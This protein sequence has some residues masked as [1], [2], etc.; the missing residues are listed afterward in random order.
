MA[1]LYRFLLKSHWHSRRRVLLVGLLVLLTWVA[2]FWFAQQQQAE[3]QLADQTRQDNVRLITTGIP[4]AGIFPPTKEATEKAGL[5]HFFAVTQQ[6][7]ALTDP[8]QTQNEEVATQA[9]FQHNF[10]VPLGAN[11]LPGT[12]RFGPVSFTQTLRQRAQLAKNLAQ[13]RQPL[14]SMR[15]GTQ[16]WSFVISFLPLLTSILGV[17]VMTL[18]LFVEEISDTMSARRRFV[19]C[20]PGQRWQ[21]FLAQ[22]LVFGTDTVITLVLMLGGGIAMAGL[23]GGHL[24]ADYPVLTRVSGKLAIWPAWRVVVST[25]LIFLLGMMLLYMFGRFVL[26]YILRIRNDWGRMLLAMGAYL[27]LVGQAAVS[28]LPN[29]TGIL[30]SWLPLNYLQASRLFFGTDYLPMQ[31]MYMQSLDRFGPYGQ[32]A[33]MLPVS[34]LSYYDGGTISNLFPPNQASAVGMGTAVI[35]LTIS[36]V[37]IAGWLMWRATKRNELI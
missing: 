18:I 23:R 27:V 32:A 3:N 9:A 31:S 22:W 7:G 1:A 11:T 16:D 20:L 30:L 4:A 25:L 36:A 10:I 15:Y 28:L 13:H 33:V 8:Q 37:L 35:S 26:T 6:K 24:R 12:D 34:N 2:W 19:A 17:L 21:L 5:T 14:A 29:L